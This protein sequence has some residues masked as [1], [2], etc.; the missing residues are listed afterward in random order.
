MLKTHN[1]GINKN[2]IANCTTAANQQIKVATLT[3]SIGNGWLQPGVVVFVKFTNTNTY[4][5]TVANPCKLNVNSTGAKNIYYGDQVSPTGINV[6][7]Y[8][9]ADYVNQYVYDGTN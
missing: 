7:A 2:L 6:I 1:N 8:G 3:D 4:S 5:S 9:E